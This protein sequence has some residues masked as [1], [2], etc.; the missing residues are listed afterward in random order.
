M[1]SYASTDKSDKLSFLISVWFLKLPSK[2]L[3]FVFSKIYDHIF[4]IK[5]IH[6]Q[7]ANQSFRTIIWA[8]ANDSPVKSLTLTEC[9][10]FRP[11]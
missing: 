1:F 2:H 9:D 4:G 3:N 10:I 6:L 11:F 5:S 7:F 8:G